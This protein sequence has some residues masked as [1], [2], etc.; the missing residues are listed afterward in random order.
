MSKEPDSKVDKAVDILKEDLKDAAKAEAAAT[1]PVIDDSKQKV[2]TQTTPTSTTTVDGVA[3][4]TSIKESTQSSAA[5]AE[6]KPRLSLWQRIVHECKHYYNGF[7]LLYLES[8]IMFRSL[9]QVLHGH[10]LTRRERK[11]VRKILKLNEKYFCF[12]FK[13]KFFLS[14]QQLQQICF[15]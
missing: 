2:S 15:V 5:P 1:T 14:L 11:Q 13:K 10:T 4:D 7:K 12:I 8:K 3:T 6:L 9:W